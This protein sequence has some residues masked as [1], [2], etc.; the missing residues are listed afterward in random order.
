MPLRRPNAE[1]AKA[2]ADWAWEAIVWPSMRAVGWW[3]ADPVC[4]APDKQDSALA[5][6]LDVCGSIDKV[7][8]PN[9]HVDMYG[10]RVHFVSYRRSSGFG[11]VAE[12]PV[13]VSPFSAGRVPM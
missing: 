13:I 11:P 2:E 1:E 4:E 7:I 10:V 8:K 5:R 6:L 3:G 9:G 12:L